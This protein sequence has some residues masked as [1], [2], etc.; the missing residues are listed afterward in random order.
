MSV[1]NTCSTYLDAFRLYLISERVCRADFTENIH[2]RACAILLVRAYTRSHVHTHWIVV[3]FV[4]GVWFLYTGVL[5]AIFF[6]LRN[7][8]PIKIRDIRMVSVFMFMLLIQSV[9][10]NI[11]VMTV[12][13]LLAK[14]DRLLLTLALFQGGSHN[15]Y[16]SAIGSFAFILY[17]YFHLMRAARLLFIYKWYARATRESLSLRTRTLTRHEAKA[18]SAASKEWFLKFRF[19]LEFR[20]YVGAAFALLVL[21]IIPICLVTYL[22]SPAFSGDGLTVYTTVRCEWWHIPGTSTIPQLQF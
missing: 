2:W 21:I 13:A 3:C 4:Q 1:A 7:K 11:A 18:Y 10:L 22:E 16:D 19:V 8:Q 5:Y 14:V 17:L 15:K 20:F 9:F 12:S 6:M